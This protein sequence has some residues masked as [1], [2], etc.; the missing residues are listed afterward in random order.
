[1]NSRSYLK[2]EMAHYEYP[3]SWRE[4]AIVDRNGKILLDCCFPGTPEKP[5][6]W[7]KVVAWLNEQHPNRA[8]LKR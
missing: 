8:G 5:R 4:S 7:E 6:A 2:D 1:M 3:F